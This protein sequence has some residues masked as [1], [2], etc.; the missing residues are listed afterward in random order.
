MS[1]CMKILVL[2][3]KMEKDLKVTVGHFAKGH[4][5]RGLKFSKDKNKGM[6]LGGKWD[7]CVR[8]L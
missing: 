1:S 2:R 6:E 4:K 3:S 5:R 7:R 8:S